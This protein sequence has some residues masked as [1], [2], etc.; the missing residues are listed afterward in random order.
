[1]QDSSKLSN[2]GEAIMS[3]TLLMKIRT[4][5]LKDKGLEAKLYFVS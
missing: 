5:D 1:M 4:A 3:F 2:L